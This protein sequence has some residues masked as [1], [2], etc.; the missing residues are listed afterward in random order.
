MSC[1]RLKQV[2]DAWLDDELDADTSEEL[3]RHVASCAACATAESE[4]VALRSAARAAMPY[5]R[6]PAALHSRIKDALEEH[7]PRQ[8]FAQGPSWW[9]AVGLAACVALFSALVTYWGLKPAPHDAFAE[10]I[11]ASH[12]ASLAEPKRLIAVESTERHVLKPWFQGKVD[13]APTVRD[14]S[15]DGF[16]LLGAGARLDHVGDK[17][18]AAIVYRVRSHVINVFVWRSTSDTD[19]LRENASRGFSIVTWAEDGLRY[20]AISDVEPRELK[21]FATLVRAH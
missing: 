20:S 19:V 11:V 4:R 17:Q 14:L 8:R 21:R 5:Y 1:A 12:V 10:Q 13:F 2:L 18:A 9:Q 6:A 3:R 15:A 7:P 16:V